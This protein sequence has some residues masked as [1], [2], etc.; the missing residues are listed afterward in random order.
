MADVVSSH[1]YETEERVAGDV[2]WV[3]L[4]ARGAEWSWLTK[5]E[6]LRLATVWLIK[7]GA[8]PA[9]NMGNMAQ[10]SEFKTMF[11]V[12]SPAQWQEFLDLLQS[13]KGPEAALVKLLMQRAMWND[14]DGLVG[15]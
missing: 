3:A 5:E 14:A 10:E 4:R 12:K 1:G 13:E 2:T 7:Y 15:G 8:K 11:E 9:V 6:A